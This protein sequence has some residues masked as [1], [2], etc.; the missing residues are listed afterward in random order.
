VSSSKPVD[1]SFT[2]LREH[3]ARS[4]GELVEL[5]TQGDLADP[6]HE[7]GV[8]DALGRAQAALVSELLPASG[9]V[10]RV[11]HPVLWVNTYFSRNFETPH[12]LSVRRPLDSDEY[13]FSAVPVAAPEALCSSVHDTFRERVTAG[14][15]HLTDV[16][17]DPAF[18]TELSIF[19]GGRPE[20]PLRYKSRL[21]WFPDRV[22]HVDFGQL[23]WY[24]EALFAPVAETL[25]V[26]AAGLR[27]V[28]LG[29]SH[30]ETLPLASAGVYLLC[31]EQPG[32]L[33]VLDAGF[34]PA[35]KAF[36]ADILLTHVWTTERSG[37][38]QLVKRHSEYTRLV[39]TFGHFIGG[40]IID[41]DA[42]AVLPHAR[43]LDPAEPA[44]A[45]V[46]RSAQLAQSRLSMIEGIAEVM[47]IRK[48]AGTGFPAQWFPSQG[49]G[50]PVAEST[51][52]DAVL[53]LV[54]FF[55]IPRWSFARR[56]WTISLECGGGE[57]ILSLPDCEERFG[58]TNEAG[59]PALP[60]FFGP[61]DRQ[62]GTVAVCVGLAE[63]L[64]NAWAGVRAAGGVHPL[65]ADDPAILLRL[66]INSGPDGR[67]LKVEVGNL[68]Y[69]DVP[70]RPVSLTEIKMLESTFLRHGGHPVVETSYPEVASTE[71]MQRRLWDYAV[72]R[73]TFWES[74]ARASA[75]RQSKGGVLQP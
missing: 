15:P 20:Q 31:R 10:S 61:G 43:K 70:P 17:R 12:Q 35:F 36:L 30:R 38:R 39:H 74:R 34:T 57:E 32:L 5:L 65:S 60:P 50:T 48:T 2:V 4:A 63:L 22:S 26:S 16:L 75:P 14:F 68:T 29:V 58:R 56:E 64:R 18:P 24:H 67:S 37:H 59:L 44:A 19:T 28:H 73:W 49:P 52:R 21:T 9:P 8:R 3:A 46:L 54:M 23:G 55:L 13:V 1:V 40:M 71:N 47:R 25:G 72:A 42:Y 7:A 11:A 33:E 51:L 41:S 6:S 27:Y 45:A 69:S 66:D 62:A 53:K